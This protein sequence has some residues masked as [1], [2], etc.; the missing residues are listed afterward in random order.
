VIIWDRPKNF[1][2][3]FELRFAIIRG[4]TNRLVLKFSKKLMQGTN[5]LRKKQFCS[6][7]SS[8]LE[9]LPNS[10]DIL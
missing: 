3:I 9:F 4:L 7:E 5:G 8:K 6:D 2:N 1:R 10:N